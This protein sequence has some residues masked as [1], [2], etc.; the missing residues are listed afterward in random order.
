MDIRK[1][2][3]QFQDS[4]IPFGC[5]YPSQMAHS[6]LLVIYTNRCYCEIL[7]IFLDKGWIEF[8][9]RFRCVL[10]VLVSFLNQVMWFVIYKL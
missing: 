7:L 10:R 5:R 6:F 8:F 4:L 2:L 9:L 1:T 3:V